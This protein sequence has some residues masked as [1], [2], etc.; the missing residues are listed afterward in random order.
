MRWFAV[1]AGVLLI[2][3]CDPGDLF[4]RQYA[5][6]AETSPNTLRG[7][8]ERAAYDDPEVKDALAKKTGTTA[9]WNWYDV[10]DDKV[11]QSVQRCMLAKGGPG[12]GGGVELP[13]R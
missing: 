6:Y 11:R 1:L 7:Q 10:V 4:Y 5:P 8:C 12:M 2:A 13:R 3:G 9:N